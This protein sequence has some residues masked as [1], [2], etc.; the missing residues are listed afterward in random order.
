[1]RGY[2]D[3]E[4]DREGFLLAR[5]ADW[6]VKGMDDKEPDLEMSGMEV[7][8]TVLAIGIRRRW[9]ITTRSKETG[10]LDTGQAR[11]TAR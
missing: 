9:V 5:A 10:A 11:S 1:L 8:D 7:A 3:R 6:E 2:V 4:E